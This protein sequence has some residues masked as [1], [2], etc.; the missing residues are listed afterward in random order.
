[1]MSFLNF[2]GGS[3]WGHHHGGHQALV[4]FFLNHPLLPKLKIDFPESVV[5]VVVNS[6]PNMGPEL[7]APR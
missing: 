6:T 2:L 1:M 5:V 4:S 7:T 3:C